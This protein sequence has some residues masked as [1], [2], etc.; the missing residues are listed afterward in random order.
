MG[1][2]T[3]DGKSA[4]SAI[5][6]FIPIEDTPGFG[7]AATTDAQGTYR[8]RMPQ[9]VGGWMGRTAKVFDGVPPGKYRVTISR[10]LH[11]DGS[12]M[13]SDE[14]PV[15]S[16]AKETIQATFSDENA[17]ILRA[18]VPPEGGTFD[19]AVKSKSPK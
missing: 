17:T 9:A 4:V 13:R 19:W 11:A 7:T 15:E 10:R 14:M 5:V 6:T 1:S 2:V 18:A 8:L 16:M 3:I 12:P